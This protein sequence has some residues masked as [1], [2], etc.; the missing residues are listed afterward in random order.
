M[1]FRPMT[2]T[3]RKPLVSAL[4]GNAHDGLAVLMDRQTTA[5]LGTAEEVPDEEV[6]NAIRSVPSHY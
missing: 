3:E 1:D 2:E 5:F 4:H 6:I